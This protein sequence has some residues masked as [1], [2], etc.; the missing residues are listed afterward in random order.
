ML[1]E[2]EFDLVFTGI[3]ALCW[4]PSVES[5]GRVVAR[6]LKPGGRLFIREGH[7]VLWSLADMGDDGRLIIEFP[8]F[9][10]DEPMVWDEQGTYVETDIEFEHTV[11]KEWNHGLGEIVTALLEQG[12]GSTRWSSTTA[13]PWDP[14]PDHFE[15]LPNGEFRLRDRPWRLPHTY[16]IS[17]TKPRP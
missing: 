6:L 16:T 3:G 2:G 8:Y 5:L 10:R 15:S 9:E 11:T 14:F 1:P 17:A 7:P 4:I 12:L 13:S